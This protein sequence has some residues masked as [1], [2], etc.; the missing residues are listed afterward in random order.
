MALPKPF[1]Y[2]F[3]GKGSF[4]GQRRVTNINMQDKSRQLL[5]E[6]MSALIT[7]WAVRQEKQVEGTVQSKAER[8]VCVHATKVKLNMYGHALRD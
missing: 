8:P 7:Y 4:W 1:Q 5:E 6:H 2:I 3:I